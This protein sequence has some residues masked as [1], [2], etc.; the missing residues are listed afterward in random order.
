MSYEESAFFFF[1]NIAYIPH[2][3]QNISTFPPIT[4]KINQKK[5]IPAEV[6]GLRLSLNF[7]TKLKMKKVFVAV[8]FE[9]ENT[10]RRPMGQKLGIW[11]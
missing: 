1:A 9:V 7:S 2:I 5:V 11:V 10:K 3:R 6:T 4:T 8:I